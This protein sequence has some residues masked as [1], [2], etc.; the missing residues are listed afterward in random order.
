MDKVIAWLIG[1]ALVALVCVLIPIGFER[2]MAGMAADWARLKAA[3]PYV[4]GFMLFLMLCGVAV[5]L[6]DYCSRKW[7]AIKAK[8]K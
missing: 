1:I 6:H 5:W 3:A 7:K 8:W 4:G 2:Q